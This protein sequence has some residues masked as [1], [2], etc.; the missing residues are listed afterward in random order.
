MVGGASLGNVSSSYGARRW[1]SSRPQTCF[2]LR[3][4]SER[5]SSR[6]LEARFRD[7]YAWTVD[8]PGTYYLQV[9]SW[10]F[11]ENR[12]AEGR[13]VALGRV[14]DLADVGIPVFLIAG[15]DDTLV[16]VAQL[17]A[18]PHL[19]GTPPYAVETL[20]EP[21]GHLSLFTG[22]QTLDRAWGRAASWLRG[23]L[24]AGRA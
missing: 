20:V 2:S 6:E 21:C 15:R 23:S 11:Q 13:F 16:S 12:I 10:L 18:T 24:P 22:K 5:P 4:I 19:I 8:L 14:I 9:V 7:W 3:R 17:L 1:A